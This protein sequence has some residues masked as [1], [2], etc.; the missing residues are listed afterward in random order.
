[1][2]ASIL[3]LAT[4]GKATGGTEHTKDEVHHN[5]GQPTAGNVDGTK[6]SKEP[7]SVILI[8]W[9]LSYFKLILA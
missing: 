5:T 4:T 2:P 6:L 7:W 1:V 8:P 3:R 9:W